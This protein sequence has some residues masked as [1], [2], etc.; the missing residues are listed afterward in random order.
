MRRAGQLARKMLELSC[1]LA[2]P[3]VTTNEI[4]AL[5]HAQ[6]V[7]AG[8]YPA[9]L[10]YRGFPK[11][12]CSAVNHEICHGIPSDR[13]LQDGD[14]VKFDVSVYTEEGYFGDNCATVMVGDVDERG[15]ELVKVTAEALTAAIEGCGPGACLS[16]V[17]ATIHDLAETHGFE[18]VERWGGGAGVQHNANAPPPLVRILRTTPTFPPGTVGT[19]SGRP[20]TPPRS[21]STFGTGTG[22]GS[23][24]EWCSRSSPCWSRGRSSAACWGTTGPW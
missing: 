1:Y 8:A 17:G 12:I 24:P 19:A 22:S 20:S 10:N 15:Q 3:G 2:Q 23:C 11:S 21:C 13:P 14:M 7:G 6:I 16:D 9:P 18:S 4:D 5:V